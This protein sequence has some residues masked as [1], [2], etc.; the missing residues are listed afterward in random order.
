[1]NA[2]DRYKRTWG[3]ELVRTLCPEHDQCW[4]KRPKFWE[5]ETLDG[6]P[7]WKRYCGFINQMTMKWDFTCMEAIE[8][9]SNFTNR[10][11][12]EELK[13]NEKDILR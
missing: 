12:A 13:I 2:D 9:Y 7:K 1:M 5:K 3:N 11:W 10:Q 6:L 4:E 8:R